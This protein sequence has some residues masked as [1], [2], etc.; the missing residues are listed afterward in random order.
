V[1]G[2]AWSALD[3]ATGTILWQ[4][5]DPMG[6]TPGFPGA[7][8]MDIGPVT[9]ANGVVYAGSMDR[10]GHMYALEAHTGK[11]LWTFKSGASVGGGPAVVN[12]VVYWGSGYKRLIGGFGIPNDK[13]Y[14]FT[15]KDRPE[16]GVR[17]PASR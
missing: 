16:G 13:L 1:N 2:G 5:P 6:V 9:V 7:L 14:A 15:P 17:R 12:G 10:E 8:A 3:A 11:I 4:T